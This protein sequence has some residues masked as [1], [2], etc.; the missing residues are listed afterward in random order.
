MIELLDHMPR[1]VATSG[2]WVPA[3]GPRWLRLVPP[4]SSARCTHTNLCIPC[5]TTAYE[6]PCLPA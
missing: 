3:L 2:R 4:A 6:P 5:V 1:S